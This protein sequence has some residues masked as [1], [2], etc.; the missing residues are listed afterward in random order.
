MVSRRHA[1]LQVG[2]VG[3]G[4]WQT[5]DKDGPAVS[6]AEAQA[7]YPVNALGFATNVVWPQ[8]N[9]SLGFKYFKE[10]S[11]RSTFQGYSAQISG[12]VGF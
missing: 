9:V 1:Q 2:L 11:N 4:Q 6:P 8:R 10:F 7:R 3:Y 5:T 12:S